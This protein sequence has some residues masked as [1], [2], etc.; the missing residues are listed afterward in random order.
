MDW[1]AVSTKLGILHIM[2]PR[3]GQFASSHALLDEMMSQFKNAWPRFEGEFII[4]Q[5]ELDKQVYVDSGYVGAEKILSL[6]CPRMDSFVKGIKEHKYDLVN[7]RKKV[8][9]LPFSWGQFFEKSD[10]FSYICEVHLFFVHFALRYPEIDVVIKPKPKQPGLL[11]KTVLLK[12]IEGSSI[13]IDKI[14][15]LIIREDLDLRDLFFECDVVCGLN[16]SALLEAAVIGLPVIIPYFKDVQN[17]KYEE[18]LFYRDA[19]D[20]FDIANDVNELESLILKRLHNQTIDKKVMEGR[21]AL[22]ESFIS[23]LD[24]D[25]TEKYVE[26]IKQVIE[27]QIV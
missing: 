19:Y 10:L 6:G 9:L 26:C 21:K 20:L 13:E 1:G 23:S 18:R 11:R 4:I 3:D 2:L 7:G 8:V 25:A 24:G 14:P 5:S 12:P 27:N 16:T 15:N 17:Q 22:F